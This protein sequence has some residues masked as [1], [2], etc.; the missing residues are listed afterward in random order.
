MEGVVGGGT[1]TDKVL[2]VLPVQVGTMAAETASSKLMPEKSAVKVKAT[3]GSPSSV[4][5]AAKAEK[6]AAVSMQHWRVAEIKR[7]ALEILRMA[8][9]KVR[10]AI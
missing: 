1:N 2:F 5:R 9:G 7:D 3:P 4:M 10:E 8:Q 6:K